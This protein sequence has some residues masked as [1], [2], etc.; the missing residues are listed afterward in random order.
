MSE[1][2][3]SRRQ[4]IFFVALLFIFIFI[5]LTFFYLN[6]QKNQLFTKELNCQTLGANYFYDTSKKECVKDEVKDERPLCDFSVQYDRKER[7]Q[8]DGVNSELITELEMQCEAGDNLSSR[9]ACLNLETEKNKEY[10]GTYFDVS[11]VLQVKQ[12]EYLRFIAIEIYADNS[13]RTVLGQSIINIE[14]E[15]LAKEDLPFSTRVY[16]D[17]SDKKIANIFSPEDEVLI[18]ATPVFT[19]CR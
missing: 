6:Y 10:H 3:K 16:I 4:K 12:A 13:D 14:K 19:T 7:S 18:G 5:L 15:I 2:L 1:I 17:R 8:I 9:F 11:G